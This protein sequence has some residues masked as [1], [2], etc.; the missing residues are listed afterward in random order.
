MKPASTSTPQARRSQQRHAFTLIELLVV[1]AII[2]ILAGMLLPALSKAKSKAQGIKCLGNIKAMQLCWAMYADDNDDRLIGAPNWI[3]GS[4]GRNTVVQES[5][6]NITSL[7]NGRLWKYNQAAAIY[8]DP[9]EQ[10]WPR[11]AAVRVKR[12]RSYALDTK[13]AGTN[14]DDDR[15]F[16]GALPG[17]YAPFTKLSQAR[18]PGPSGRLGF[19]DENEA[20][21]DD[22]QFAIEVGSRHPT[23]LT[24]RNYRNT[25]SAR[26][27]C[28]AVLGFW[29]GHSELWKW[30]ETSGEPN[31]CTVL[32]GVNVTTGNENWLPGGRTGGTGEHRDLKRISLAILNRAEWDKAGPPQ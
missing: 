16:D 31:I 25:P 5:W 32:P 2:A 23:I 8:Q 7:N 9:A 19:L 29:D 3:S 22:G 17:D 1:I 26:H 13:S 10:P 4:M 11:N 18:F 24:A 30:V 15:D 21:I 28:G 6:T 20:S 27:T 14:V 12:L